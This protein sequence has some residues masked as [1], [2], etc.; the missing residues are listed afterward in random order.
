MED[1]RLEIAEGPCGGVMLAGHVHVPD[2]SIRRRSGS[3]QVACDR[4]VRVGVAGSRCAVLAAH[5]LYLTY[6]PHPRPMLISNKGT[7]RNNKRKGMRGCTLPRGFE[8]LQANG[9]FPH[10]DRS[11]S[12]PIW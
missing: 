6:R 8:G 11:G 12:S 7:S 1:A 9:L 10:S 3:R 2:T 5:P 4:L